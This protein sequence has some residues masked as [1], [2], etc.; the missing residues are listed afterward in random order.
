MAAC[1]HRGDPA[2]SN[3]AQA[4]HDP[5]VNPVPGR[6]QHGIESIGEMLTK[7]SEALFQIRKRLV[8]IPG[9]T[10]LKLAMAG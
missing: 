4:G 6:D 2:E 10:E 7:H 3:V 5:V 8:G 1:F 9:T